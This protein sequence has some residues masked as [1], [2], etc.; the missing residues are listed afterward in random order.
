MD[1]LPEVVWWKAL[2]QLMSTQRQVMPV[3]AEKAQDK[4][5]SSSSS[6]MKPDRVEKEQPKEVEKEAQK[7]A[8]AEAARRDLD[9]EEPD[10]LHRGRVCPHLPSL[11]QRRQHDKV[12]I[13]YRSWCKFCVEAR[14]RN[15]PHRSL[16]PGEGTKPEIHI[17]YA[18]SGT[19]EAASGSRSW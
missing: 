11:E 1:G 17:D 6:S 10:V 5:N 4:G 12:H 7:N 14:G 8:E 2:A 18:F 19:L 9:E 13:P 15:E 3:Q 16:P